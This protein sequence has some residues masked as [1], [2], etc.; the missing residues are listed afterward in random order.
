MCER[1]E[2][3]TTRVE[4]KRQLSGVGP[5]FIMWDVEI[6]LGLPVLTAVAFT[7]RAISLAQKQ[8]WNTSL[9]A[10]L[11]SCQPMPPKTYPSH[12]PYIRSSLILHTFTPVSPNILNSILCHWKGKGL[13]SDLRLTPSGTY[14]LVNQSELPWL[15]KTRLPLQV[16][17]KVS[18]NWYIH[19]I[20]PYSNCYMN[21]QTLIII[22][23]D[24]NTLFT[25][26]KYSTIMGL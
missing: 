2:H 1:H 5:P 9:A 20:T 8:I 22:D 11:V 12:S 19:G 24:V 23:S 21:N 25:V 7:C 26:N 3:V 15:L 6:A 16:M 14:Y 18:D 10:V 4:V 17:I 13:S